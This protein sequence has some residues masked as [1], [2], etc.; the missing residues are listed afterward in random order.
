MPS[1]LRTCSDSTALMYVSF[2]INFISRQSST[3]SYEKYFHKF[4]LWFTPTVDHF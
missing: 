2:Y 1:K 3:A 4:C